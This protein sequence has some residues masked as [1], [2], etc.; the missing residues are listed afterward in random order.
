MVGCGIVRARGSDRRVE[1]RRVKTVI[2][3]A[4]CI[5]AAVVLYEILIYVW[6]DV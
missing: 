3:V 1:F 4:S 2:M 5:Y 6:I